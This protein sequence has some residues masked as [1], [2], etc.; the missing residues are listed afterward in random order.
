MTYSSLL[1][2]C[3]VA[4][5]SAWGIVRR[6]EPLARHGTWRIGGPADVWIE[7]R[8]MAALTCLVKRLHESDLP[9]VVVGDGSNILFDD[10]GYRGVVLCVGPLMSAVRFEPPV[11]Q[12]EAGVAVPRLSRLVGLRGLSG[13]EH[14]VGIPGRLGGLIVMNGGSLRQNIGSVIRWVKVI[15]PTGVTSILE[16]DR[17]GFSYRTSMF[18]DSDQI[19]VEAGMEFA[20]GNREVIRR[21]MLDDLRSRRI[22]FPRVRRYPNCGSV[23]HSNPET[24]HTLGPTG[25]VIEETGCKGWQVGDAQVSPQHANFIVNLGQAKSEDVFCLIDRVRRAVHTRTGRWLECEVRYL[26]PRGRMIPAHQLLDSGTERTHRA[27]RTEIPT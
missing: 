17:C 18:Q 10:A 27:R 16:A 19:V 3:D 9:W 21:Q 14:T 5:G 24:Y 22:K 26:P 1:H 12:A 25:R 7:P 6:N 15:H 23:F 8:G 2:D 11:V 13:L 20:P 4:L